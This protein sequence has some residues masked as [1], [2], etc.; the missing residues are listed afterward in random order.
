MLGLDL[1][2]VSK[3]GHWRYDL[4]SHAASIS[5]TTHQ[6]HDLSAIQ[7]FIEQLV[8]AK[9]KEILKFC[10]TGPLW[11]ASINGYSSNKCCILSKTFSCH[12]VLMT[13]AVLKWAAIGNTHLPVTNRQAN[14][15]V[16]AYSSRDVSI[17]IDD[18]W[19]T[20]LYHLQQLTLQSTAYQCVTWSCGFT[21]VNP[22]TVEPLYNTVHYRRY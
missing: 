8:L 16:K 15:F 10:I 9:N 14:I 4:Q 21:S 2:H 3:R 5:V 12:D 1:I 18:I 6:C 20:I 17:T 19:F 11:G 13:I 22:Y 7:L